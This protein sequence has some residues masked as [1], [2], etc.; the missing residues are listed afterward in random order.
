[1]ADNIVGIKFGVAGGEAVNGESSKLI[2]EQLESLSKQIT[3]KVNIN[4]KHFT[5]QLLSLRKEINKTL[6]NIDIKIK[7]NKQSFANTSD[8]S[9]SKMALANKQSAISEQSTFNSTI[10]NLSEVKN[11]VSEASVATRALMNEQKTQIGSVVGII[12]QLNSAWK[13]FSQTLLS[14]NLLKG[15]G[16]IFSELISAFD[17]IAKW[18]PST[19]VAISAVMFVALS[20]AKKAIDGIK[21]WSGELKDNIKNY[22]SLQDSIVALN[23]QLANEKF[24]LEANTSA[25][26]DLQ[27][28]S[29]ATAESVLG[30][31]QKNIN[32][33]DAFKTELIN[34]YGVTEKNAESVAKWAQEQNQLTNSVGST[35][36][37]LQQAQKKQ[38]MVIS[39]VVSGIMGISGLILGIANNI[40]NTGWKIALIVIA[41]VG[42]IVAAV[43][44]GIK[45]MDVAMKSN[46]IMAAISL[47]F[48]ALMG[49]IS[50]IKSLAPSYENL[51]EKAKECKEAWKEAEE[52]LDTLKSKIAELEDELAKLQAIESPSLTEQQDIDRLKQEIELLKQQKLVLEDAAEQSQ[53]DAMN[54]TE[55]ALDKLAKKNKKAI[56]SVSSN[57]EAALAVIQEY[58][59]LLSGYEYGTN[60]K[61]DSYFDDYFELLDKYTIATRGA[62]SAWTSI[63]ARVNNKD[64]VAAL[65]EFANTFSNTSKMTGEQIKNLA[66]GNKDIKAFFDYLQTVGMWDGN[67]WDSLVDDIVKLRQGL[68]ELAE[69]D[70]A[71]GISSVTDQFSALSKALSDI[72]TNGM[73]SLDSLESIL[74]KYPDLIDRYF[75]KSNDGYELSDKFKGMSDYDILQ[76][77]AVNSLVKYQETLM[78]TEATLNSLSKEDD[79]YEI[80]LKNVATAQENLNTQQLL[81]ATALRE[82]KIEDETEKLEKL[83]ENLENQLGIYKDLIDIR[84]DI[85]KTYKEELDYN[86]QLN[87]KQQNVADLKTQLSLAKLDNSASGQA[88]ARE[89]EKQLQDA[90]ED[91]EEYTLQHAIEDITKQLD[92]EYG[93]YEKFIQGQVEQ[94]SGQIA[95][96]ATTLGE[97]SSSI[98]SSISQ[99]RNDN[100]YEEIKKAQEKGMTLDPAT[101]S[102]VGSV[103][104]GDYASANE[105]YLNAK[106]ALN[107]FNAKPAPAKEKT[108]DELKAEQMALVKGAWGQGIKRNNKGDN[109]E[110]SYKGE[111][112]Y[113]ESAGDETS[114]YDAAYEVNGYGDRDI[115]YY[116]DDLYGCLDGSI[117]KLRRRRITY[118]DKHKYGYKSLLN[119]VKENLGIYHTGGFVGD[120]AQLKSNE[121]FAKL[122]NGEL[123][124][125][126]KQMDN[127]MKQ[128]LPSMFEYKNNTNS[129]VNNS[130]LVEIKCNNIDKGTLP[131]LKTLTEQA[132]KLIEGKMLSALSRTGYKKKF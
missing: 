33:L 82:S 36:M 101:Q 90:E 120:I 98:N 25:F 46:M 102:F 53:R 67:N 92:S 117:I 100:L 108:E 75:S 72:T 37:Q 14:S 103:Q 58:E 119:K 131:Q 107:E 7:V 44:A 91:L 13:S 96:I 128:V 89:L 129:I 48:S 130:P 124:S 1:M 55:K 61:L 74:S 122:L 10:K 126:P 79:D 68:S 24:A 26:N 43:V 12:G 35:T 18:F 99:T 54:A 6:G 97:I 16:A 93:E 20:S 64:A 63:L 69:I 19:E 115:F 34:T 104:S 114:L 50:L 112:Y 11:I 31:F 88:R 9:S 86:K 66:A 85:L 22:N 83:Q 17:W 56:E 105:H 73:L 109:G 77:V 95:D 60:Q 47:I 62:A 80:A 125:T 78:E 84:K 70:V 21:S 65:T 28:G 2:R 15:G 123:V 57:P 59:E 38:S 132:A 39:S 111:T 121:E 45:T 42:G 51:K 118:S 87:K 41:I 116:N 110:V 52:E 30:I 127:F 71:E 32:N 27:I 49:L 3:L 94:I 106:K 81:W 76:D 113:V 8:G 29:G 4:R 23:V 5:Q 40:E